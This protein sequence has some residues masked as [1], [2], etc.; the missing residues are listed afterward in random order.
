MKAVAFPKPSPIDADDALIDLHVPTPEPGEQDLLVEVRAVSVNPVDTKVRGARHRSSSPDAHSD[1]RIIG[2]DAAGAVVGKGDAVDTFNVGDEVFYAGELE[3]PGSNAEFQVVDARIVGRKPTSIGFAE[4][5]ALPLTGLTA[6]EFLFDRLGIAE[7]E[8][9][10][11]LLV[12]GAAGGVGSILVQL[13]RTLTG[14]TIV[15]TASRPETKQW[16][17]DM[18][19]HYVIDHSKPMAAQVDALGAPPVRYITSLTATD[20]N[21]AQLVDIL[22]P[23]GK[24]GVIDDPESLDAVPLKR[25]SASLHWEFM[26]ARSL[27]RTSDVAEQGRILNR[28][29]DLVDAGRIRSTQTQTLNPINAANLKKAHAEIESG[30][31]IGKITL[32]GF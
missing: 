24:L 2:W 20:R 3:R 17:I 11:T 5:A 14:L 7:D 4:A 19:A 9:D 1:P 23:Q 13:A 30:R 6:W 29:A 21:Y 32:H 25:K 15:G 12:S 8:G 22:A 18:G 26:F 27:W 31:T 28:L 10:A 16:A